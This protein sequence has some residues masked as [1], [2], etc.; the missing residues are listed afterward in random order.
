MDFKWLIA[1]GLIAGMS[2]CARA[3]TSTPAQQTVQTSPPVN[4]STSAST[5]TLPRPD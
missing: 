2:A 4:T 3:S 5:S 1:A